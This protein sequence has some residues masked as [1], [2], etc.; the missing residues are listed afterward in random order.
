ELERAA[1]GNHLR[2]ILPLTDNETVQTV[3]A[4]KSFDADGYFVF[5]TRNGLVKRT[6]IREYGNINAAGLVAINLL[7]DDA[8]VAVRIS[9]GRADIVLGTSGG[10]AI[11]FQEDDV[12]D[13][14][15]AT[16]GVIGIRLRRSDKVVS[17]VVVQEADKGRAELLSVT[18]SGLGKRT[19]LSEYP[20]QGRG[21]QGVI[22]HKLTDRTG[23]MVS[24]NQVLGTEELF[25][26]T[27]KG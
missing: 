6:A 20:L 12:R 23:A 24:L 9:D 22:G 21:G 10:Q 13:T 27:E 18:E 17:L 8:L 4:L 16:Q 7:D 11:R 26:L 5:A 19:E 1:R 14:G 15:R 3:L 25:V 2:N